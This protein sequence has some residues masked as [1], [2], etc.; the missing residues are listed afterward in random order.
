VPL[1][2]VREVT[3][4]SGGAVVEFTQ[5]FPASVDGEDVAGSDDGAAG[6]GRE[7]DSVG[8][9]EREHDDALVA[10]GEIGE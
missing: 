5:Q 10:Q 6:G 7:V 4:W 3:V 9:A 8:A 2:P 1:P